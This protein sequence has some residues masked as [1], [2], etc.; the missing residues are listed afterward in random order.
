[1]DSWR[2]R[3]ASDLGLAPGERLKS[4]RRETG[5]LS[6]AGRL[7][8]RGLAG[9]Y[10]RAFHRLRVVGQEHVPSKGPFILVANHSSHLDAIILA[11]CVPAKL[12]DRLFPLAAGDTFFNSG[13]S[14]A[15]AAVALNAL[16]IWR[17][18]TTHHHLDSLR[19]R[20]L[21]EG[22]VYIL[23]PEGTRSRDG[24]IGRFKPGL[25]AL[26]AGAE[27]PVLPC[28]IEGAFAALPPDRRLPRPIAIDV[29]IAPPLRF[30][31]MPND[32]AGW[33]EISALTENAVRRLGRVP[34]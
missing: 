1:M 31:D 4:L 17:G 2:Y 19:Q 23:F 5:L 13:P 29:K 18:R 28:H 8:W 32:K 3:P 26:I 27:I 22:C 12:C 10:L 14:S 33:S 34:E 25:G 21:E 11:S 6:F 30:T 16:P 9:A 20:L 7:V 15:W 24:T